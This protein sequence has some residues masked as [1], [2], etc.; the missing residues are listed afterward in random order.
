LNAGQSIIFEPGLDD[1][2]KSG[3]AA[4]ALTFTADAEAAL[5]GVDVLWVAYDTPVDE[6]DHADVGFVMDRVKE[7]LPYLDDGTLVLISSQLPAGSVRELAVYAAKILPAKTLDFAYSPENLRLGKAI[8]VFLRPDRVV[9]GFSS[10]AAR[11]RLEDLFAPITDRIEWMSVESAEM[12]KHAINAFLAVS[13]AFANEIASICELVGADAKDMERGMKTEA[14]IGPKAYLSPGGPF[15]G[16]TLARD[17]VYLNDIGSHHALPAPVLQ[18]VK[19]SNDAHKGWIL[20]KISGEFSSLEHVKIAVW[21]LTY[22]PGID[23]LRCSL[24]V[25]L[26]NWLIA[27]GAQLHVYDPRVVTLPEGW[28]GA[29]IRA[30]HALDALR[31]VDELVPENRTVL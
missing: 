24:A 21:G 17:I 1:L 18:A 31:G 3:M 14:R 29:V 23:T 12:T 30:T 19:L 5:S 13:V 6:D 4:G 9:V 27:A 10:A 28:N 15:A 20:R 25:E 22:K 8:N 7:S 2:L 11:M 16:G 26:C